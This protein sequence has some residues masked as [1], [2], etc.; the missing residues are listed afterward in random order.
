MKKL[1]MLIAM[2][3]PLFFTACS[4]DDDTPNE[5]N[6]WSEITGSWYNEDAN[7]EIRFYESGT[8]YS[9]FCNVQR[10]NETEGRWEYDQKNHKLTWTYNQTITNNWNVKDVSAT[11]LTISNTES[12]T[13]KYE[14]VVDTYTLKY[15]ETTN[16][17]LSTDY[18]SYSVYSY[19]SK[20]TRLASVSEDGTITA[21]GEKGTTYVKLT[22]NKGDIW[23][24]V[25]VGDDC[26][27]LWYDYQSLM[28]ADLNTLKQVLGTPDEST[29]YSYSFNV[30]VTS[31]VVQTVKVFMDERTNKVSE[32]GIALK[33]AVPAASI[34][35]YLSSHYYA[36]SDMGSAF[37][38]TCPLPEKSAAIV[39]YDSTNK[40]VYFLSPLVYAW[41]DY[42][43][44]FGLTTNEIVARFGDLYY[45]SLAFY[46]LSNV[47]VESIYFNID[48]T[49]GKVVAY[50]MGVKSGY[51]S[52]LVRSKLAALYNYWKADD[53][54]TQ[55]AYL[56]G[57]TR[58][59]SNLMVVYNTTSKSV[60]Y[61]DLQNYGK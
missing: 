1:F 32:I 29:D 6:S 5:E 7:E 24:R 15:G 11:T 53:T 25:I 13:F 22:T 61:Y 19:S 9:R 58:N 57:D 34:S 60:I 10:S 51:D 54:N 23:V 36:Y 40:L 18:S 33:Q 31:D 8:F 28:G 17:Q 49:T 55:F 56:D 38:A 3:M 16:I 12:G 47:W 39:W 14:R 37:Y 44:T 30:Y 27:D 48:K 21:A 59:T 41:P 45:G 50:E 46:A 2:A 35:S 43:D 4:D 52:A 26:L 20:N 42:T